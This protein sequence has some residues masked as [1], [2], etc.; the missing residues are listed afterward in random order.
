MNFS[1]ER[2]SMVENQI[3]ARGIEDEKLLSAFS[4]V[5]RHLFVPNP[6]KSLSY[7]DRPLS[8]GEGQ[9]ISQPYIV[10]LMMNLSN[11]KSSDIVLDIGTGSGY[12]TALLAEIAEKVYT[13]ERIKTLSKD[14]ENRLQKIGYKNIY[15]QIG[16]GTLGWKSEK[17]IK[18]DAI[19]ISAAAPQIPENLVKQLKENGRMILPLGRHFSQDLV[20]IT[21]KKNK[22]QKEKFGGCM[23]VPLIGKDGW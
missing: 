17:N 4:K 22:I 19:I 21:K 12:Q 11:L 7:S 1:K 9:T 10:A 18:F 8:I 20:R 14:A 16:D 5:K 6:T 2:K 23:F 3:K 13:I 15:F